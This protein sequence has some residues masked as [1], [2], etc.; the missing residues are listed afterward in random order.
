MTK[1]INCENEILGCIEHHMRWYEVQHRLSLHL[2][3]ILWLHKDDVDRITDEILTFV[4][5][6]YDETLKSFIKLVDM[7]ENKNFKLMHRKQQ[8]NVVS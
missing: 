6:I 8:K 3:I 2:H 4:H 7:V 1:Y 5:A